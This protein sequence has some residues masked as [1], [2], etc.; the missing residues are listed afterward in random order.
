[1][2]SCGY[3]DEVAILHQAGTFCR[4]ITRYQNVEQT[5]RQPYRAQSPFT[6]Y[7]GRLW[8]TLNSHHYELCAEKYPDSCTLS[9]QQLKAVKVFEDVA[10]ELSEHFT[11]QPGDVLLLNNHT[12]LHARSLFQDGPLPHQ[13]RHLIRMWLGCQELAALAPPHLSFECSFGPGFDPASYTD[14]LLQPDP[15]QFHVPLS[16]Q[17]KGL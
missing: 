5:G 12:Q 7:N 8:S 15:C 11:L 1:M 13:R 3:I 16:S 6:F 2:Q 14:Q 4:D 10:R 17:D 9:E